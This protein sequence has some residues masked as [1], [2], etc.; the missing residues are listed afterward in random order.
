[1]SIARPYDVEKVAA[2]SVPAEK[3]N[4]TLKSGNI[5]MCLLSR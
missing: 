4:D 5:G 3:I 2:T 1:M